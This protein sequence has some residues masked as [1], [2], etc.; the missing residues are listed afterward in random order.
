MVE[1][2]GFANVQQLTV[3]GKGLLDG[4]RLQCQLQAEEPIG[5]SPARV[6]HNFI[7]RIEHAAR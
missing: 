2:Q 4:E 3:A 1:S 7:V 5:L 6:L